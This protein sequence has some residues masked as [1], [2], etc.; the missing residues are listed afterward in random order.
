MA[1]RIQVAPGHRDLE[2][3]GI[4][5]HRRNLSLPPSIRQQESPH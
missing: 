3:D 5:I 4:A 1:E 2:L